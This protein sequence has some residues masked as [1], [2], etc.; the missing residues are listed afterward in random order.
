MTP[1]A[2][3]HSVPV[4]PHDHG[5]P[6]EQ[7]HRLWTTDQGVDAWVLAEELLRFVQAWENRRCT[8]VGR[9]PKRPKGVPL[10]SIHDP[11]SGLWRPPHHIRT[12]ADSDGSHAHG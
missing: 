1:D 11:D 3:P 9:P 12:L 4:Q 7:I 2:K 8:C 10:T 6:V 5:C